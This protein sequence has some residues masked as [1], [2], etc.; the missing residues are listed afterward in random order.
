MYK[1]SIG[2]NITLTIVIS[3]LSLSYFAQSGHGLEPLQTN[4][5]THVPSAFVPPKS[6]SE[7]SLCDINSPLSPKFL[8]QSFSFLPQASSTSTLEKFG[9]HF[10][11]KQKYRKGNRKVHLYY[12]NDIESM[13]G[14]AS[15]LIDIQK[16]LYSTTDIL[17][18]QHVFKD[19]LSVLNWMSLTSLADDV[20]VSSSVSSSPF[21]VQDIEGGSVSAEQLIVGF[22]A[23]VFPFI[24]AAYE[25]WKRIDTQQRCGVCKGSG[26]VSETEQGKT[27]KVARKCYA[28]GGFIPWLGWKYFWFS[29]LNIG[30]GGILQRPADNYEELSANAKKRDNEKS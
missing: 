24:W 29:N 25:F 14:L 26:L 17:S 15:T 3:L 9:G 16:H 1:K 18:G 19:T 7:F 4:I 12:G 28:C 23:G 5:K 21:P 6:Q 11:T 20:S 8:P 30:N 27:L 10:C 13:N 22:V 2:I